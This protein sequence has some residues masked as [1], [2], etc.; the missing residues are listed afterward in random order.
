MGISWETPSWFGFEGGLGAS[1]IKG[2]FQVWVLELRD[3][4]LHQLLGSLR[5]SIPTGTAEQAYWLLAGYKPGN[6]VSMNAFL[7]LGGAKG[8]SKLPLQ[9]G[10]LAGW[11]WFIPFVGFHPS[12]Q[13]HISLLHWVGCV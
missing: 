9:I 7:H 10:E 3:K 4:T 12:Q 11:G 2:C 6:A 13:P 5:A 1:N 8:G